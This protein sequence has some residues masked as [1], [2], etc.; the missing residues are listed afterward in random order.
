MSGTVAPSPNQD[1]V[2]ALLA[3]FYP[4]YLEQGN[5]A[6]VDDDIMSAL[7][8]LADQARPWCLPPG[9]QDMAQMFFT[10][11][12]VTLRNE[13]S[14]GEVQTPVAGPI[15]SEKEGDI[16]VN[17]AA[18]SPNVLPTG[19]SSRPSSDAWDSWNRLY[20]R[21]ARGTIVTR[22]GDP[23]KSGTQL[24]ALIYPLAIGVWYP[25]W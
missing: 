16:Q 13:T 19:V 10:A 5:P 1:N 17:Y 22:Y 12:L 11:Y 3:L 2:L 21:C 14:S 23:C 15:V 7:I 9:Q 24:T 20:M 18:S 6:N 8:L 25:I 4:Q